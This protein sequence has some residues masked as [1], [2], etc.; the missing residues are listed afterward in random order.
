MLEL[1]PYLITAIAPGEACVLYQNAASRQ[2]YGN[3]QGGVQSAPQAG[4]LPYVFSIEGTEVMQVRMRLTHR[5]ILCPHSL[6]RHGVL[7]DSPLTPSLGPCL[8]REI[9]LSTL[10]FSFLNPD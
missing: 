6:S 7:I 4:F 8:G 9:H 1:S 2:H 5:M 3:M 10:D